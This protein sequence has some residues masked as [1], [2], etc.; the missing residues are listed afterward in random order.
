MLFRSKTDT[1]KVIKKESVKT[2]KK[3]SK[4]SSL[5]PDTSSNGN[6]PESILP[7]DTQEK[8]FEEIKNNSSETPADTAKISPTKKTSKSKKAKTKTAGTDTAPPAKPDS[9]K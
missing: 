1:I 8:K 2:E 7:P 5:A 3:K 9:L 4:L 6:A